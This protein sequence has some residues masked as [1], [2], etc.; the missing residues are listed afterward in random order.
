MNNNALKQ[1]LMDFSKFFYKNNVAGLSLGIIVGTTGA[2]VMTSLMDDIILP[3]LLKLQNSTVEEWEKT[4]TNILGVDLKIKKFLFKIFEFT[5]T[6][7]I[8]FTLITYVIK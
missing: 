6:L 3:V 7:L 5:L 8:S 1:I 4:R 2:S